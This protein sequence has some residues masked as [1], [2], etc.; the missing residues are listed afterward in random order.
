MNEPSVVRFDTQAIARLRKFGSDTLLFEMIDLTIAGAR[1]RLDA[2]RQAIA[3]GDLETAR[4]GFHSLKS[5]SAQMGAMAM[6]DLC[7]RGEQLSGIGDVGALTALLPELDSEYQ[8]M[9][10]WLTDIRAG[11]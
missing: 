4:A 5:T 8:A 2:A 7:E 1:S 6:G 11:G 9:H 3:D 10:A